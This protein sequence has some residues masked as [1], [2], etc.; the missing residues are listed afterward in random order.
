MALIELDHVSFQYFGSSNTALEDISLVIN[1][2][3]RVALV[4]ANGSGKTTLGR[5]LNALYLPSSGKVSIAGM[6]TRQPELHRAIR[7]VVGM[8]FQNP[9]DQMVA[10]VVEEDVAF[11]LEN[12]GVPPVEMRQRVDAILQ[13]F[14]LWEHRQRPPHLLSSGQIQRLALAGV[15][16]VAPRVI[17][18]DETTAML[19]PSGRRT[20]LARMEE[21]HQ[22]GA[23]VIAITHFMGEAARAE[24]V[25]ALAHGR[26]ALDG[27]PADVFSD[28]LRLAELGLHLPP[29]AALARTLRP[30]FPDLPEGILNTTE[31]LEAIPEP[32]PPAPFPER[33]GEQSRG[34]SSISAAK[35]AKIE[36]SPLPPLPFR[37][38]GR[39]DRFFI[40][41]SSP[42]RVETEMSQSLTPPRFAL[43][44]GSSKGGQGG[45]STPPD[46]LIRVS[47][48]G[49]TYLRDTPLAYR[50]LD[51]AN[52][53]V[54]T[55]EIYGLAGATGSGKSTL[56]QH[57]NGLLLPQEGQVTVGPH[58]LHEP[59]PDLFAARKLAG[60]AFQNPETQL[61]E[62]FVGDEIAFGP[63][64]AGLSRADIRA[65]VR[66]A[67]EQVGLDFEAFKDRRSFGLSG[68]E[69]KKVA[70]ASILA[71]RPEILLLDEPMAGLDPRS[72]GELLLA[73]RRLADLGLTIVVSS[74]QM[75]D[76]A[77]FV[78]AATVM[79]H[80]RD[81]FTGPVGTVFERE[82]D[83]L[84][85]GLEAPVAARV[86]A[87]LRHKGWPLPL[88][89]VTPDALLTEIKTILHS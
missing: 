61:F 36:L 7:Q 83:L 40:P 79:A 33:K 62:T 47:A 1:E 72:R 10:A 18:F 82:E 26:I 84:A 78:D 45:I 51:G 39:G 30:Y 3:E 5:L 58:R 34:E 27:P 85:A 88:G 6:D 19:D 15:L 49:H 74:H 65:S 52:L 37:E 14:E 59:R 16:V 71:R 25:I 55:G 32:I 50:A 57:L 64:Q 81:S 22:Q 54:K 4:G 42:H 56:L 89:V 67:M 48:L 63:R 9:E 80:G 23:T 87:E 70:L 41:P 28:P 43:P 35:A 8:V 53:K 46:D 69:R 75:D 24:R 73:L 12:L 31:L 21:L 38:G 20:V 77:G 11:G 60:L 66:W 13:A 29:A 86:A 68:G 17:V 2:G 76:L 44:K